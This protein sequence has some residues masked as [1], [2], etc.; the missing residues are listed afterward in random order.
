M[1]LGWDDSWA[2]AFAVHVARAP[3]GSPPPV[4]ARVVRVDRGACELLA[5][6]GDLRATT[7]PAN[8]PDPAAAPCVGDWVTVRTRAEG[9]REVAAVLDRRTAF[10]RGA[11]GRDSR[12]GL[13][14]DSRGQVL[15]ANMDVAFVAEPAAVASPSDAGRDPGQAADPGRAADLGQTAGHEPGL[16]ADRGRAAS[17]PSSS[18]GP[19]LA[20]IERLVALAWESGATPVVLI[21]KADLADDLETLLADVS[22]AAPGVDVHAVSAVTGAGVAAARSYLVAGVG[23][24]ARTAVVLGASGAGKS[25]LV[26]ALAAAEVMRTQQI[27]ASDGRGRH[28]TTHRELIALPGGG[29]VIDTPGLRRIGL[30]DAGDGLS[31]AFADIEGL[32]AECRFA[33]CSHRQEPGCA[34]LAAIESGDLPERRLASWHKLR[35]EAEWIA[36]RTDARLRSERSRRWRQIHRAQRRARRQGDERSR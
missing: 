26:N 19:D 4:P 35:R 28:T 31:R 34:V 23:R 2:E 11:V 27:R 15:A 12:G 6:E 3:D 21:T 25:T 13:S 32:A 18:G 14:G 5:A 9:V 33:D 16:A 24:A 1:T 8:G 20:R 7:A 17:A 36:S 10:V 22:A 29:L 30:F